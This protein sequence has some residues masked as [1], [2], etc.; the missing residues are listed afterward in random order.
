MF[1]PTVSNELSGVVSTAILGFDVS[2]VTGGTHTWR[3][4]DTE[5]EVLQTLLGQFIESETSERHRTS[6]LE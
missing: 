4:P 2:S 1:P 3:S 5:V 6:V